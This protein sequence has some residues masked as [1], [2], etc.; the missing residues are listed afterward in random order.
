MEHLKNV[1]QKP[2]NPF[3]LASKAV[4]FNNKQRS[5]YL[6]LQ[7]MQAMQWHGMIISRIR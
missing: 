4:E 1:F 3:S 7:A 2:A 6:T 5:T